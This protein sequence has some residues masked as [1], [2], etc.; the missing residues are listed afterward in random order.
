MIKILIVDDHSIVRQGLR[1]ILDEASGMEVGAE[2]ANGVEALKKL[3][4]GAPKD[5]PV[6]ALGPSLITETDEHVRIRAAVEQAWIKVLGHQSFAAN[7]SWNLEFDGEKNYFQPIIL[8]SLS[9]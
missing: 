7:L 9:I 2:A 1:R 5:A 3:Q 4:T 8:F 6:V